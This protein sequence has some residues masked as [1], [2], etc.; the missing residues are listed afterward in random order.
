MTLQ[1]DGAGREAA[2][3]APADPPARG[4]GDRLP[5]LVSVI[6]A[7]R[8]RASHFPAAVAGALAQTHRDLEVIVVDDASEDE[9]PRLL[10][11]LRGEDERLRTV[12]LEQPGGAPRARNAGARRARG[13]VLA[14][15]DDDCVW[16]T[17]KLERQLSALSAERGVVYCRQA[18]QDTDGRW[19]VEGQAGAAEHGLDALLRT[20]YIGTNM[21]LIRRDLFEA[22]DGF[23]ESLPRLQDW[24]LVLR[25][26][27]YTRFAYIP[28]V[29][30]RGVMVEGGI[31]L[32]PGPLPRAAERMI[33]RHTPHL[34]RSQLAALHYGLGKFLLADGHAA[35]ARAFFRRAV[36]LDPRSPLHWAGVAASLLGPWSARLVRSWRQRG[37]AIEMAASARNEE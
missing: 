14:F 35:P 8:D 3:A 29:L 1:P 26:A 2:A 6:I 7:T 24:D 16:S 25:L 17:D 10:A 22:V 21:L 19:I 15:L 33:E 36:R 12:R 28:D 27:R 11:G 18:V 37:A 30:V 31:S 23:D 13:S 32:T 4:R 34:T 9:T 20:N 5:P